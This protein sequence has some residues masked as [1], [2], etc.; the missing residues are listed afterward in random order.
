MATTLGDLIRRCRARFDAGQ[1]QYITDDEWTALINEAAAHLHNWLITTNEGYV[2]KTWNVVL[3]NNQRD[4]NLPA[5]FHK[6]LQ[7]YMT[8]YNPG[9]PASVAAYRPLRR[10]MPEEYRGGSSAYIR[11]PFPTVAGYTLMG[12]IIRIS[13]VPNNPPSNI[14]IEVQYAP[15]YT[16][17]VNT[18]DSPDM[19]VAPGW[20]EFVVNQVVINARLKEESDVTQ[21][22]QQQ[23]IIKQQIE[24]DMMSR[25]LGRAE[26]VVD[27]DRG[28]GFGFPYG[29]WGLGGWW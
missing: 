12:N 1:S 22:Q 18:L 7:V 26:H 10:L 16:A 6:D 2:W 4:Y 19:A 17:M 15:T 5:D 29:N 21:L 14:G 8:S 24:S 27:A 23:A 11:G 20:D 25:D 13:P 3:A 9:L 28:Y